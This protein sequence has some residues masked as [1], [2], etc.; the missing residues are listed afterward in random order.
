MNERRTQED[1]VYSSE[2]DAYFYLCIHLCAL[3]VSVAFCPM[4]I[5]DFNGN[6]PL[7]SASRCNRDKVRGKKFCNL[8]HL[9]S[10]ADILLQ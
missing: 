7:Q 2:E 6:T 5:E 4:Q 10:W 9:T 8:C 3:C 1:V